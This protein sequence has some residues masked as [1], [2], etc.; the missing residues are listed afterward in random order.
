MNEKKCLKY[1]LRTNNNVCDIDKILKVIRYKKCFTWVILLENSDYTNV[2]KS[3][4][5]LVTL[6]AE[7]C[8]L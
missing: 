5:H 3:R 6:D 2:N 4:L 8:K 1:I 7:Y